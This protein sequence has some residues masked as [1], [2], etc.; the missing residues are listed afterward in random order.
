M[1]N[2]PAN[3]PRKHISDEDA[4]AFVDE[5]LSPENREQF[6]PH[7]AECERCRK[8]VSLPKKLKDAS[9]KGSK[10]AFLS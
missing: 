7:L 3:K 4:A 6:I 8:K 2:G 9:R 5:R 1:T 10:S